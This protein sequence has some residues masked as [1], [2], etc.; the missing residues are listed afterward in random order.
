MGI[1]AGTFD[2]V[3]EGHIA[4]ARQAITA[5]GLDKVFFLVEPRPRRKQGVRALE[6]REAMVR[7]AIANEVRFGIIQLEQTHF[8]VEATLPKIQALFEGAEIH[9]LM[10]EDIIKHLND[11]PHVE[12]LLQNSSFIVGIRKGEAPKV[13]GVLA[14][15]KKVRN[16]SFPFKLITT[17]QSTV[18]S[19][20]IRLDYKK[21]KA[22]A[23]VSLEV[24]DYIEKNGLYGNP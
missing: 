7:L 3:H 8:S 24:A 16:L 21:G 20:K 9:F 15:I 14:H 12:E 5:C 13:R 1:Y 18:S 11:W 17:E 10:G 2:P 6:H 19:S 23:G 22:P 4:F